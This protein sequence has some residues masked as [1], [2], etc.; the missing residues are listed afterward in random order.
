MS[1]LV[2]SLWIGNKLSPVEQICLASF[3]KVNGGMTLYTYSDIE[4]IPEGVEI[5]DGNE[6]LDESEIFTYAVG[7][8]K[9][10]VSAFSNCFRYKLL[11]EKGGWWVDTDVMCLNPMPRD[12]EYV[13]STEYLPDWSPHVATGIIKCSPKSKIM[14]EC[15]DYSMSQ[16]RDTLMW[17]QIGP[18]LLHRKV[19]ELSMEEYEAQPIEYNPLHGAEVIKLFDPNAGLEYGPESKTIHLWNEI[20]RRFGIDKNRA[21]HPDSF[22]ERKKREL[23]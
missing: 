15:F 2:Q 20:W 22:I 23:L 12:K 3:V 11:Y 19:K 7:E 9:G 16:D 8:G 10:S 17:G 14:K 6:I 5:K 13:F 21:F 1:D 18:K 4:G